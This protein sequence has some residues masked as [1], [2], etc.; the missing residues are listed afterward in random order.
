MRIIA[1]SDGSEPARRVFPHANRLAKALGADLTVLRVVEQVQAD[2]GAKAAARSEIEAVLTASGISATVQIEAQGRDTDTPGAILRLVEAAA[3]TLLATDAHGHNAFRR[4]GPGS[5]ATALLGKAPVP[6]FLT[7]TAT[8]AAKEDGTYRLAITTDGSD[9]SAGILKA[10]A[11]VLG[12]GK[13]A[14]TLVRIVVP[15]L[16][17]AGRGQA[18]AEE[19][20]LQTLK[21]AL[22]ANCQATILVETAREFESV[23]AAIV[24]AARLCEA[25]AIAMSTHGASAARSFFAGSTALGVLSVSPLPVVLARV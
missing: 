9:A 21:A 22:P 6:V 10:L 2:E 1:T 11:P 16:G 17:D 18:A 15:R 24:R 12:T 3:P 19:A 4:P 13:V 8:Q 7:G 23:P 25:D 20:Q 5:V 14:V